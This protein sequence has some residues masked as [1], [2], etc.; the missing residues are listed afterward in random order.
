MARISKT[1]TPKDNEL[2]T[3][4][5]EIVSNQ[6]QNNREVNLTFDAADKEVRYDVGCYVDRFFVVDRSADIS[7][8]R[9]KS[10]NRSI[11]F[12]STGAGTVRAR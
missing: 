12:K 3:Q 1:Y 11:F 10:D 4:I 9:T 5:D 2:S 8:Y 6:F 7:V